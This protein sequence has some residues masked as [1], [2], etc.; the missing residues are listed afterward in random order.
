MRIFR[1]TITKMAVFLGI[2]LLICTLSIVYIIQYPQKVLNNSTQ[3]S[4]VIDYTAPTH[5]L[6]P[7][8]I[9]MDISGYGYPYVFANDQNEQQKIKTLGIKYMRM[10]LKYSTPGD[11]KSL[12]ICAA[13]DCDVRWTSD[14]W[15]QAIKATG[16]QPLIIVPY[17]P[18]DAANMV[19]HF[20]KD[21][22]NYVKYWVIG[23]EPDLAGVPATEY[24]RY[25]NQ[26][27]DAMKAIDPTIKIG[28]GTTAW[29]DTPFLQT[30]LEFSGSRVDFVDFHGYAQQGDVPGDYTQLFRFA[31]GYGESINDL[32]SL[33]QRI[34]PDRASQIDIEVGEW[35]LNWGGA[36]QNN[37][38]FH[39]V[40]VASALGHILSSGGW[41]LFYADKENALYGH[42]ESLTDSHG[43]I[44]NVNVDDTNPAY[45]G[46]GMFTGEQ[47]F[48]GFGDTIVQ[49]NTMLP[50]TEIYASNNPKNI[51]VIN[52]DPFMAETATIILHDA[53]VETVNVWRKDESVLFPDPPVQLETLAVHNERFSYRFPPFSITTFVLNI[54]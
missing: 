26:N 17:S 10:D 44:M 54:S 24:S 3:D 1:H 33:I 40:W 45:H 35:E 13:Q 4:I 20:N 12:I 41:S 27:Y 49:A 11:P 29:Y 31:A 21:T 14:Q 48:R 16:A 38:N 50:H 9:G 15:V 5:K 19:K 6:A 47:L 39:A 25:F 2:L 23:N 28:G 32:R 53:T 51:V 43:H 37:T 30:F 52:K 34:V 22:N 36:A 46:I 8:A 7:M 42:R 18:V